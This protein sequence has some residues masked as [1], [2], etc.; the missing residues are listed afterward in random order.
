[1]VLRSLMKPDQPGTIST[2]VGRRLRLTVANRT[3][4][5]V[6]AEDDAKIGNGEVDRGIVAGFVVQRL[7]R[8]HD[9]PVTRRACRRY[10]SVT[11]SL[12]NSVLETRSSR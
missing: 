5:F 10:C 2:E 9:S 12:L 4:W 1:M 11:V 7:N 6:G 3:G 8:R